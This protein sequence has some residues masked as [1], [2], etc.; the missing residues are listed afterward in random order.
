MIKNAELWVSAAMLCTYLALVTVLVAQVHPAHGDAWLTRDT[1][2]VV[3][4]TGNGNDAAQALDGNTWSFWNP[5]DL[6][7]NYNNWSMVLDLA[8]PYTLTR[9]AVTSH[10]D[11]T[12][13]VVAFK[14]QKSLVGSPY[15]WED[16]VSVTNVQGGTSHRQEFGGFHG[17]ARYWRF[18]VTRTHS[19]WQPY[20]RELELYGIALEPGKC[21]R[22]LTFPEPRSAGNYARLNITIPAGLTT[23][24]ACVQLRTTNTAT[25]AVFSYASQQ[26]HDEIMLWNNGS[27][28]FEF[29]INGQISTAV[30]LD[31]LDGKCHMVCCAWASQDGRWAFYVDG[32]EIASDSGL[33][34]D[35]VIRTPG[36]WILAQE[37]DS[38]GGDFIA[39]QAS[40]CKSR[41]AYSGDLSCFNVWDRV[42]S[43]IE[44][45]RLRQGSVFDW[46]SNAW[47]LHGEVSYSDN[48]CDVNVAL[49]KTALQTSTY[50]DGTA[51]RAVDGNTATDWIAGSCT[52]TAGDANPSCTNPKCGGE[53][54]IDVTQPIIHV[55]CQGMRGRYVGV[56]L[57]GSIRILTLCEV[58]IFIGTCGLSAFNHVPQTDCAPGEDMVGYLD[59][60]LQS[61]ADACCGDPR[62]LSFQYTTQSN[63]FLKNKVCSA[64]EKSSLPMGNMYDRIDLQEP[65]TDACS[66]NPCDAQAN[67]TDDPPPA[68][69]ATCT[70]NT[71]TDACLANPCDAQATCTDNP[72]PA[73]NATCTCNIGY[74]GDGL[75]NGTG[76]AD[77]DAC[78]DSP[79]HAQATCTDNPAPALNATCTCNTGYTGD[80]FAIGTGCSDID[81]CSANPCDVLANCTDNPPP[82]LNATCTCNTGYTGDGLVN[83]TGCSD[84]DA[85]LDSP[86]HAQATCTDNPP[87]ALN[88]TCTC[89]TGYTGDGFTNGTGCSAACPHDTSL[90]LASGKTYSVAEDKKTYSGAQDECRRRGGIVAIPR[91]EEE[92]RNLVLL[93]NCVN[94][95]VHFWLGIKKTA[96][97]WKDGSG[98]ALGSFTSWAPKEPNNVGDDCARIVFGDRVGKRRDN[99]ADDNCLKQYRYVC[100][101]ENVTSVTRAPPRLMYRALQDVRETLQLL[102]ANDSSTLADWEK[103]RSGNAVP[104]GYKKDDSPHT[105]AD[106]NVEVIYSVAVLEV[107]PLSEANSNMTVTVEYT[108]AWIDNRLAELTS[109]VTP[110]PSTLLWVPPVA[111][112]TTVR[113]ITHIND[114][115]KENN[116]IN[117]WLG[118]QGI[119]FHKL[120]RKLELICPP[121]LGRYPFD[122]YECSIEL[123]GYGGVVFPLRQPSKS[124]EAGPVEVDMTA[125][126]SQ[127]VMTGLKLSSRVTPLNQN[128]GCEL[129]GANCTFPT[130][131]CPLM[132][133]CTEENDECYWCKHFVGTCRYMSATD[134][135]SNTSSGLS[136]LEVQFGFSRRRWSH[137]FHTFVPSVV[138]VSCSWISFWL[139]PGDIGPRV[140]LCV[141][142]LLSLFKMGG[143]RQEHGITAV[144]A[145]DVWMLGGVITVTLALLETVAVNAILRGNLSFRTSRRTRVGPSQRRS[146]AWAEDEDETSSPETVASRVDF[147]SRILF[148]ISFS[149]FVAGF[150]LY[151]LV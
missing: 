79:C 125:V 68:L 34:T 95:G 63:C 143:N 131:D 19:D 77:K 144:R 147:F 66:A 59:V 12:H 53:H 146:T 51:S 112:G 99:W 27:P 1:S 129:F 28:S 127:F 50:G 74:T 23:L 122:D 134:Q 72:A 108:M 4:A 140:Q 145:I 47:T 103:W 150:L 84:T 67:C 118:R 69:D 9:I 76:C 2:W 78:L 92:Q 151:Y 52:H 100:E 7:Q 10:G 98:T 106:G 93:K 139:H 128:T 116:T 25:G 70:C 41:D 120:T 141:T 22:S 73:L 81:A 110:V 102:S 71:D 107:G 133:G 130:N 132:K 87:P 39:E 94:S 14:L 101:I 117:M 123:H 136:T 137:V 91:D 96:G 32:I 97:V 21:Y 24:T 44:T 31:V 80:G 138:I 37:Q 105:R 15:N 64:E 46:T 88:A 62:C 48:L 26:E 115:R 6:G 82:A 40:H 43:P 56:R 109:H 75:V 58:Q 148:P 54:Q 18:L 13:D 121:S 3:D 5:R 11:T 16:V 65:D 149:V 38:V 85:C 36:V 60:S 86:C 42:L 55:P 17:T 35:H 135:C 30:K 83:G 119:M 20:L 29:Y 126:T 113:R 57:P 49:T 114:D 61:C 33:A 90:A 104:R 45:V 142:V 89:N 8:E 111:F 124:Y